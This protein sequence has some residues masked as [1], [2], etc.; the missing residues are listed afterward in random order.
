MVDTPEIPQLYRYRGHPDQQRL[1]V[2]WH[3]FRDNSELSVVEAVE[4]GVID[5]ET[6]CELLTGKILEDEITRGVR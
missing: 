6:A 5:E 3:G 1:I 4:Q 2:Q